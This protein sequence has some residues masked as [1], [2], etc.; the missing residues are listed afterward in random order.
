MPPR[1]Y[2]TG[3]LLQSGAQFNFSKLTILLRQ[4][5]AAVAR[6]DRHKFIVGAAPMRYE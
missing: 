5:L 3:F 2:F 4:G 6:K 1:P